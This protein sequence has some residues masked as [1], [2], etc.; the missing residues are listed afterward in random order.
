M[1]S[2]PS[3]LNDPT[4][5]DA[6]MRYR[7]L[8]YS[9][10]SEF[11]T[12]A[13]LAAEICEKPFGV[14]TFVDVDEVKLRFT[15]GLGDDAT[16][17]PN[18]IAFCSK[19]V[20]QTDLYEIENTKLDSQFHNNPLVVNDPKIRS[21]AGM[22]LITRDG[23]AIGTL[24]VMGQEPKALTP[25]QK[26][27][28]QQLS[29][30]A[31]KLFESKYADD[32]ARTNESFVKAIDE[33]VYD[34][35]IPNQKIKWGGA[36]SKILGYSPEEMGTDNESWLGRVHPN[37]LHAVLDE[38]YAMINE[39]RTYDLEYRFLKR[40]GNFIWVHDRG[41]AHFDDNGNITHAIG[42][43]RNINDR[44]KKDKILKKEKER[45]E[46]VM[47]A[48]NNSAWELDLNKKKKTWWCSKDCINKFGCP[49]NE[50]T[51]DWWISRIHPNDRN[52]VKDS[53][54]RL[55]SSNCTRWTKMYRFK[56]SDESYGYI[57]DHAYVDRNESGEVVKII[58]AMRDITEL[59]H[60][61]QELQEMSMALTYAM[62]GIAR[63]NPEGYYTYVNDIYASILGYTA[64]ELTGQSW[65][66]TVNPNDI[67]KGKQ[68]YQRMLKED[69]VEFD[70]RGMRKDGSLMYKHVLIAKSLNS[71]GEF[72]GHLCFMKDTT[73][74]MLAEKQQK[75]LHTMLAHYS[76]RS[77]MNELATSIAHEL[78]QPLTAI[79]HYC[80]A[81]SSILKIE[82][83]ND[84]LCEIIEA[85]S[86]QIHRA[87]E[88]I[89]RCRKVAG[90][91]PI[92]KTK[93]Q[94]NTLV[95]E[96]IHLME[97]EINEKFINVQLNLEKNI[98]IV[99]ID[100]VQIQQVLVNLIKNSLDAMENTESDK[101]NLEIHSV[102]NTN[103]FESPCI[104]I[105]VKDSG[106]GINDEIANNLFDSFYSTK[107]DGM[108]M[109]LS[110]S[111]TIIDSH[112]GKIWAENRQ[113]N[114]SKFHFVIPITN[115]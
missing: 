47:R 48:T 9:G 18:D 3:P 71:S 5:I 8:D 21:Y 59:K 1:P 78:N 52:K 106:T 108:G 111:K 84:K 87:G 79:S 42:I 57:Q 50:N 58:G 54:L 109:G 66:V 35:D 39:K 99:E 37:D 67:E 85:T 11:Q 93:S 100:K 113:N 61:E 16:S 98:P 56:L 74:Q 29:K 6:L 23:Y 91:Q 20:L 80:D 107:A 19:T 36:Y 31:I 112:N 92:E 40:D 102:L 83:G 12:I 44:V 27:S 95:R 55:S 88:I 13:R 33:I 104:Q 101:R 45:L 53:I 70:I 15:Y 114:G 26:V 89:K 49:P 7:E 30:M 24:C 75:R 94:L 22:P 2:Q 103:S 97:T 4:R 72:I 82:T 34:H 62:P 17:V 46:L 25:I 96:T 60:A 73:K 110:I 63:L 86:E 76:R 51:W 105:T 68:G 65:E 90:K 64:E 38:F 10:D 32:L 115:N 28:L 14:I 41:V 81:A 69:K 43:I 77:D